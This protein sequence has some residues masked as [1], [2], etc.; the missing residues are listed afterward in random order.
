MS[1]IYRVQSGVQSPI[2]RSTTPLLQFLPHSNRTQETEITKK[3]KKLLKFTHQNCSN[4][5]QQDHRMR[6]NLERGECPKSMAEEMERGGGYLRDRRTVKWWKR[7]WKKKLAPWRKTTTAVQHKTKSSNVIGN[8]KKKIN[9]QSGLF[10][11]QDLE[12][13]IWSLGLKT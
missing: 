4:Q 13:G 10:Q 11:G 2:K 3:K 9:K 8:G 1:D 6:R 12:F 5:V 7:A